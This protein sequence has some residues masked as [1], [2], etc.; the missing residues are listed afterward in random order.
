MRHAVGSARDLHQTFDGAVFHGGH[1]AQWLFVVGDEKIFAEKKIQFTRGKQP[2]LPA[3]IHRVDHDEQIRR[4]PVFLL[5]IVFLHLRRLAHGDAVLDGQ[6]M[7]MKHIFQNRLHLLLGRRF[8]VNPEKQIRVREQ[9][10]HQEHIYVPA[11]QAA[12]GGEC[13]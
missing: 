3:V 8:K 5:G 4:E 2:V 9:G 12:L 13:E 11:V 7:K 6:R 1:A 10:R